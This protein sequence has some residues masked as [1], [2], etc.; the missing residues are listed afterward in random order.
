MYPLCADTVAKVSPPTCSIGKNKLRIQT[1]GF[2]NQYSPFVLN[3][4]KVFFAPSQK[5]FCNSIWQEAT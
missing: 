4:E 5:H 3:L 2:L 1:A